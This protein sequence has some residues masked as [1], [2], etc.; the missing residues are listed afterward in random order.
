MTV[1]TRRR[2]FWQPDQRV[3]V[4]AGLFMV[5]ALLSAAGLGPHA[6]LAFLPAA[7]VTETLAT[8]RD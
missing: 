4:Y 7:A 6:L 3:V 8:G 1:H 2:G 5:C